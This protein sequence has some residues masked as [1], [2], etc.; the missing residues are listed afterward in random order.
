MVHF[1]IL[2]LKILLD[3]KG[4]NVII[5]LGDNL[6]EYIRNDGTIAIVEGDKVQYGNGIMRKN[7]I[8]SNFT[9]GIIR[10]GYLSS[11]NGSFEEELIAIETGLGDVVDAKIGEIKDAYALL[12][13]KLNGIDYSDIYELSRIVL[14]TVNEFFGGFANIGE[15]MAYYYPNDFA[16]SKDNKISNLK[17]TGA[18]MCVERASLA[19]N[20]LRYLGINSFFKASG[21][22]RNNI[23]EDH[24]YNLIEFNGKYYIFDTSIPNLINDQISP[25]IAEITADA[26]TLISSPISDLG[27]SIVTSHFNPY[28]NMDVNITYDS[29]R[30]KSI[31]VSSLDGFGSMHL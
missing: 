19:Q 25:L 21:I 3:Y 20:L 18:A 23:K 14:E 6:M 31:E 2:F 13:S 9:N 8:G 16:E 24:C 26:F 28:R 27:I 15:R 5:I 1:H 30:E 4:L 22:L 12:E 17:G 10:G 11:F 7:K 29:G